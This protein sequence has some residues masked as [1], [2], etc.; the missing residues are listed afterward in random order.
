MS[1]GCVYTHAPLRVYY[2]HI[3][4]GSDV[5][6]STVMGNARALDGGTDNRESSTSFL[7]LRQNP[8]AVI[9]ESDMN[10]LHNA[11]IPDP[12][13]CLGLASYAFPSVKSSKTGVSVE[14]VPAPNKLW[15]VYRI[16]YGHT[17]E[18]AD[19]LI[20]HGTYA[21][22]AMVWRDVRQDGKKH[23]ILAPLLNLVFAYLT[24]E[25]ARKYVDDT[26][27]LKYITFYYD[28][29]KIALGGGNP[30]LVVQGRDMERLVRATSLHD[31]HVMVV[32]PEKCKFLSN[33]EVRVTDGPFEGIIGRVVR[34]ARQQRVAIEI[35]GLN[36]L[37][38]TAYIPTTF[39]EKIK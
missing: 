35:R 5:V 24:E 4:V 7:C 34:V 14:Y 13:P 11:N 36:A 6:C 20:E 2:I 28:H 17:M 39:L 10:A 1:S 31:E 9:E 21:Y 27:Q 18:V 22:V 16:L 37:I 8:L 30:P 3:G 25:Q 12:T 26:P 29:F 38:T 23:R 15:Y 32:S 33:D 19:Y